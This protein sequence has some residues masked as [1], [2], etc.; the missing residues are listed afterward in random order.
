MLTDEQKAVFSMATERRK[1]NGIRLKRISLAAEESQVELFHGIYDGWV[2]RMGKED[3]LDYLLSW[4]CEGEVR[5]REYDAARRASKEKPWLRGGR[6]R[7]ANGRFRKVSGPG[8]EETQAG[9]GQA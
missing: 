9:V 5:L 1:Q 4:L 8:L 2:Q 6:L 3:A 7:C